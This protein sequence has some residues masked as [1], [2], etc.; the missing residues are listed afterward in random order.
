MSSPSV[1]LPLLQ[2]HCFY[3]SGVNL[4][5]VWADSQWGCPQR[6][7]LPLCYCLSY[8][9]IVSTVPGSIH[10]WFGQIADGAFHSDVLSLAASEDPVN[11]ADVLAKPWPQELA[12]LI[13]AEPV[14]VEDP[15][16]LRLERKQ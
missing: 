12:A 6:Y 11:D 14:D 5:L 9:S 10:T 13:G 16:E 2:F 7:P 4:Y 8:N 3:S 1:L 15:G